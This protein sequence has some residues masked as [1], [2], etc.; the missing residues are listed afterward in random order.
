MQ[1]EQKVV[2]PVDIFNDDHLQELIENPETYG[3]VIKNIIQAL[4]KIVNKKLIIN[5]PNFSFDYDDF[6]VTVKLQ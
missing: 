4:G 3:E 5:N 6:K 1:Q 2:L